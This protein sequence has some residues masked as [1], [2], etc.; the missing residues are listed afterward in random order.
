MKSVGRVWQVVASSSDVAQYQ[1]FSIH[2]VTGGVWCTVAGCGQPILH[3]NWQVC[4]DRVCTWDS[5]LG[6]S[7]SSP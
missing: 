3:A 4:R 5:V 7:Y 6:L 1:C 2:S